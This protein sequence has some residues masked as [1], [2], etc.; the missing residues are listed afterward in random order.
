MA[1]YLNGGPAF[2]DVFYGVATPFEITLHG[3]L[4]GSRFDLRLSR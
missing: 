2:D 1:K 4:H 3:N